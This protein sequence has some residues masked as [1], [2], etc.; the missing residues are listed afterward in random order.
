M[1]SNMGK[2]K[3]GENEERAFEGE[4]MKSCFRLGTMRVGG[5]RMHRV[6][7]FMILLSCSSVERC[8]KLFLIPITPIRSSRP[9]LGIHLIHPASFDLHI[10]VSPLKKSDGD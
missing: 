1:A 3:E 8:A 2:A 4:C 10:P 7:S 5:I 9:V 6:M